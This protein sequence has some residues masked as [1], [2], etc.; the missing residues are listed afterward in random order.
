MYF[1]NSELEYHFPYLLVEFGLK[2]GD[3]FNK[4]AHSLAIIFPL[5]M[6]LLDIC[7]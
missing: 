4:T 7:N 3:I 2:H 1:A 6:C 5:F